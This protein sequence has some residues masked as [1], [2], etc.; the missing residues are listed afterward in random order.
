MVEV[1]DGLQNLEKEF[2][3]VVFHRDETDFIP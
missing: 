2:V 3:D 1:S